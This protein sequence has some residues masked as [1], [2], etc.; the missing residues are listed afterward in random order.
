MTR[1]VW[2]LTFVGVITGTTAFTMDHLRNFEWL[3]GVD[4]KS[5]I[6]QS[7]ERSL[8]ETSECVALAKIMTESMN[9]DVDPCENFY[10]YAC[11]NWAKQNPLPEGKATWNPMYK[12]NDVVEKR[13]LDILQANSKPDDLLGLKL[14]RR[15]FNACM[16]TDEL[17]RIG[18]GPVITSL[19]RIGGWPVI[20]EEDEWDDELYKW[21]YVDD[22]YARLIGLNSLYDVAVDTPWD[23][24][25]NRTFLTIS[26][27]DL[28]YRMYMLVGGDEIDLPDYHEDEGKDGSQERGSE[29]RPKDD[30]HDEESNEENEDDEE[31]DED[32]EIPQDKRIIKKINKRLGREIKKYSNAKSRDKKH[33]SKKGTRRAVT[34]SKAHY[35]SNR[36]QRKVNNQRIVHKKTIDRPSHHPKMS[37]RHHVKIHLGKSKGDEKM[38][39]YMYIDDDDDTEDGNDENYDYEED[40]EGSGNYDDDSEDSGSGSGDVDD[41]TEQ[42]D[43]EGSGDYDDEEEQRK[44][45]KEEERKEREKSKLKYKEYMYNVTMALIEARNVQ[46]PEERIRKDIDDL[47]EFQL[48]IVKLIYQDNYVSN[49]TLED[50]QKKYDDLKPTTKDGQINWARK[51]ENLLSTAGMEIDRDSM[52]VIPSDPYLIG[53]RKLL[54]ETPSRTIVNYVHWNFIRA[55]VKATTAYMR[56]LYLE[57]NPLEQRFDKRS[58]A[59]L[60]DLEAKYYLGYEYVKRYFSDDWLKTASDMVDDIQKEVEHQIEESTWM[61]DATREFILGKLVFMDKLIGYPPAYRNHTVMKK[62]FKGLSISNSHFENIMSVKRYLKIISLKSL[63][64]NAENSNENYFID[65]LVVNAFYIPTQNT[66]EIT[67]ADFQSPFYSP[68]QPWYT[69]FGIIGF[70]MAHEVNHGFDNMGRLFDRHGEYSKWLSAMADKAY[71][72]RA[73]CFRDQFNKYSVVENRTANI[74]IKDYGEQTWGENIADTMGLQAVFG[75]YQRRQR[76]CEVPDPMLPGLQNFTNNQMFFLSSANVWCSVYDLEKIKS[77][78]QRDSHSL[79]PLRVIGSLSNSEDFAEAYGCPVG[80]PMNPKKKCSI[81]KVS[82]ICIRYHFIESLVMDVTIFIKP[83]G[84]RISLTDEGVG[85]SIGA[86]ISATPF[87]PDY[88]LGLESLFG[89]KREAISAN[90]EKESTVCETEECK[91]IANKIKDSI[92]E[93]VDPCDDFYQYAC[94]KWDQKNPVPENETTWSLWEMVDKKIQK[95]VKD[96]IQSPIESNDLFAV[97]LAKKW[98]QSCIKRDTEEI[99]GL[100]KIVA[101]LWRHG[102]WPLIMQQGEWDDRIYNWQI[103][104]DHFARLTGM[105]TFHDLFYHPLPWNDNETLVLDTPH[106]PF[107]IYKLLSSSYEGSDTSDENNESG[108]GSQENGSKEKIPKNGEDE[109]DN[110]E[111]EGIEEDNEPEDEEDDESQTRIVT[112]RRSHKRLGQNKR[113][114]GKHSIGRKHHETHL[115]RRPKRD[116]VKEIVFHKLRS[117]KKRAKHGV[118]QKSRKT[119]R[120]SS[121]HRHTL[122]GSQKKSST[123]KNDMKRT[124]KANKANVKSATKKK[125]VVHRNRATNDEEKEEVRRKNRNHSHGH[126]GK[127][128]HGSRQHRQMRHSRHGVHHAARKMVDKETEEAP[129]DNDDENEESDSANEIDTGSDGNNEDDDN[130]NDEEN[131]NDDENKNEEGNDDGEGNE[132]EEDDDEDEDEKSV[133]ELTKLYREYIISVAQK[134]SKVRGVEISRDKLEKDVDALIEFAI[135]VG[136]S[137]FVHFEIEN[138][139]LSEFQEWYDG[140]GSTKKNSKVNWERKVLK[141]FSEAGLEPEGDIDAV[142]ARRAYFEKLHAILE[143]TPSEVIVNY[144]HWRFVNEM[145]LL[146]SPGILELAEEWAPSIVPD[147]EEICLQVELSEVIGYEYTRKHFPANLER[148]ARDMID[149]IQKEVE[150]QIKESTWLDDNT[151]HFILDKLVHLKHLVGSPDWYRNATMVQRYFQGLTIGTSFYENVV[152][153]IRYMK[154]KQFRSAMIPEENLPLSMDPL[155]VNAFFMPTE[156]VIAISAA[157]LQNPFFASNRPWNVNFGIIGSIIAHEV[158]HG[159]DDSGHL[160]DRKGKPTEWLSV[161]AEAYNRRADCFVRQFDNYELIKGDSY[162]VKDFGNRTAGENIADTMGLEAVFRAYHRRLRQ[163]K[164]PDPALPGLEKFSNNQTFFLSFANLWCETEDPKSVK[165]QTKYD[166]HSPGRLRVIGSVSNMDGFAKSFNCP[167]G[168]PMNPEKKCNIWL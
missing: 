149:D 93:S 121:R 132:E 2:I 1:T 135:K 112:R 72:K 68:K 44:Q 167:A 81:W 123:G 8:C 129:I 19:W 159:F 7:K 140:L 6:K 105:N 120:K 28:P 77:R 38:N 102:G 13:L 155:M 45:R 117:L 70:I 145:T 63:N 118:R 89:R 69:N 92:D 29:E 58:M 42:S 78:L 168:S 67:A 96:L 126:E 71:E 108:E 114:S 107:G 148:M 162:E 50:I 3:F 27:P 33:V 119:G 111:D 164:S 128:I 51:V 166:V 124:E 40:E 55:T 60:E 165:M 101:T 18:L 56:D 15:A 141:L 10:E 62:H 90:Q 138:T 53:L 163:C 24:D 16:D 122:L 12:A 76:N 100:E 74:P 36:K 23:W 143:E 113:S 103:V 17:E 115:S 137:T 46:I 156:N 49:G 127:T 32:N 22:Y 73:A 9:P 109:E 14:S 151:K 41:D 153:Y 158:N 82:M 99:G 87:F 97:K 25:T 147:K 144:I 66:F 61:D 95:Q 139:T 37:A 35:K 94:G 83:D 5:D 161:M 136:E 79:A 150:Y 152:N 43:E 52:L 154:W 91:L 11:G 104:D 48:S 34:R 106:L 160:Y 59:C 4:G 116:I 20:M 30:D 157:D 21:Q 98:Y 64:T 131:G 146:V 110:E 47:L 85:A 57:W 54:D 39:R 142:I 86:V 75:A 125:H 130:A 31:D 80:S 134:L 26:T 65:P 84:T 133:E 88:P